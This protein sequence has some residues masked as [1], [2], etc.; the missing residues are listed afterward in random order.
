MKNSKLTI[1]ILSTV[2]AGLITYLLVKRS[3]L[4]KRLLRV[5]E[6]GYETAY[7]VLYP[8]NKRKAKYFR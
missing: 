7:D 5:S 2:A 1:G 3:L 8:L 6:E 4:H